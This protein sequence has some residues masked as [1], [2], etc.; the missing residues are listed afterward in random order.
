[1]QRAPDSIQR[2]TMKGALY[3]K[4]VPIWG[5]ATLNALQD[6]EYLYWHRLRRVRWTEPIVHGAGSRDSA[7]RPIQYI[8]DETWYSCECLSTQQSRAQSELIGT[9]T[10][11]SS[12]SG[13]PQ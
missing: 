10:P 9:S 5:G 12:P 13:T 11:G 6:A 8:A 2:G 3:L 4:D 1:M 7:E